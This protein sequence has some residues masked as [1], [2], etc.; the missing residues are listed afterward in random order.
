MPP[1]LSPEAN[2]ALIKANGTR[3]TQFDDNAYRDVPMD[4]IPLSGL[5]VDRDIYQAGLLDT[6]VSGYFRVQC[7]VSHFAYDDPIVHPGKPGHAHLHMFFGNTDTNAYS[8]FDS[9][10]NSG[11][12]TCNG[13]DL[14][15][16]AYW[17]PALLDAQGN[18][19]I[20]Y[21]IM[22]YYKN[23]NFR[24]NGANELV[25]PFPD[26]LRMLAGDAGATEPQTT[27]TGF[28][29]SLPEVSFLCGPAYATFDRSATI[30]DCS[31][32]GAGP[33]AGR[34]LE[35][36]IAFPQCFDPEAGTY[37]SDQSHMS[38]SVNGYYGARCP[39]SHPYDVSSIMYRIFFDPDAYGGALT[40]LHLSSDVKPDRIL[41][42]GTT[43]HADWFGAWHPQA[44]QMWVDN[45]NNTQADCEVGL[46]DRDPPVSMIERKRGFYPSGYRAAA[47][48]L[49]ELCPGKVLDPDDRLRSVAS[50]RHGMHG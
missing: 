8:T 32:T 28:P 41:P 37:L 25:G 15:R 5:T 44:M 12:G 42:G 18:A 2:L 21:D 49:I 10:L 20:P 33:Y 34:A 39:D 11:T 22:V 19:L 27:P 35:M 9:L 30:P 3:N 48:E 40:G 13:E 45:C 46:L 38:Y 16:T 50:C 31:G 14:N 24:L 1:G 36:Q 29:G 47:E 23:D 7:E 17:V 43:L 4:Q 6:S 26:N